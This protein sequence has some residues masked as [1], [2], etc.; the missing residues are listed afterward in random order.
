M[1]SPTG[2]SCGCPPFDRFDEWAQGAAGGHFLK[3]KKNI[4]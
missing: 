2:W 1:F 3:T 4:D